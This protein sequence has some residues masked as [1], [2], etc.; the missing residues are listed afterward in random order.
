MACKWTIKHFIVI[1]SHQ[2]LCFSISPEKYMAFDNP[3]FSVFIR[4]K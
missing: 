3:H 1:L 2:C 4:N